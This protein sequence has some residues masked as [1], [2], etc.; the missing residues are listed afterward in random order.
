[1]K[2][3]TIITALVALALTACAGPS[4]PT[5]PPA[6]T[7]IA[8]EGELRIFMDDIEIT[9]E[10]DDAGGTRFE[11]VRGDHVTVYMLVPNDKL[12][13]NAGDLRFRPT[14]AQSLF[15]QG[16]FGRFVRGRAIIGQPTGNDYWPAWCEWE[17]AEFIVLRYTDE[18]EDNNA[19]TVRGRSDDEDRPGNWHNG[20]EAGCTI[21]IP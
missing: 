13:D 3:L 10:V 21:Q 11:Y 20:L 7:P 4:L 15:A 2:K 16:G 18:S 14:L 8:G 12:S 9:D 1:M 6:A 5:P 19:F 17:G